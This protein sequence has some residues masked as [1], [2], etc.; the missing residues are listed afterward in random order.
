[1]HPIERLRWIARDH[2]EAPTTL[3]VEAAWAISDLVNDEPAAV[4]TA[5]R[6]LVESH[7]TVGPL[8]WVAATVLAAG[9]PDQA[10]RRVVAELI[11]DPTAE[12]L[13]AGLGDQFGGDAP[14]VVVCPAETVVEAF[15]HRPV[16]FVRAVGSSPALRGQVRRFA[17]VAATAEGFGFEEAEQ[18]VHGAAAVLVEALAA[19]TR[20]VLVAAAAAPLA[21]VAQCASVPLWGVAGVGRVLCDQLLDQVLRRAGDGVE[22]VE[23]ARF[24][25]VAGPDGLQAPVQALARNTCPPAPELLVRAR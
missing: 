8:W 10:A 12:L 9:D 21:K 11:S 6:R 3:A 20:G 25:L 24:D 16:A 22:L 5:C 1:M 19:G 23:T 17:T 2:E 18:A 13:A 7:V 14:L 15:S 4:I